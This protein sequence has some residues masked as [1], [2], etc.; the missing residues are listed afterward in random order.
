MSNFSD[1]RS[2]GITSTSN[3]TTTPLSGDATYTGT[4]EQNDLAQVGVMVKTDAAG[5]LYFDFSSDGTNWD[6]TFPTAGFAVAASI[7]EFHTAVKLGRY[8]RVRLVNGSAAQTY[9]RL[10]TYFGNTF[11]PSVAPVNQSYGLDSDAI[12]AKTVPHWLQVNRGLVGGITFINKFG[13]NGGASVNDTIEIGGNALAFP[14][15]AAVVNVVSTSTDDD[16]DPQGS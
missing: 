5:T 8:F 1:I 16:G 4:G 2:V 9:M 7:P 13:K 12:I 10:T 6:S 15:T 3:S 14:A 11:V